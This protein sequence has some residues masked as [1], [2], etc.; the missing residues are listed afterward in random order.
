MNPLDSHTT[1]ERTNR[2][3]ETRISEALKRGGF[4]GLGKS[5]RVCWAGNRRVRESVRLIRRLK[6]EVICSSETSGDFQLTTWRYI[7]EDSD[8]HNHPC[9]HLNSYILCS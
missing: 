6:M 5:A 9:E 4:A 2:R 7:L 8:V 1:T 3:Q